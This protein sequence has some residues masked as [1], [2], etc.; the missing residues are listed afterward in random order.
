MKIYGEDIYSEAAL[1]AALTNIDH[2]LPFNTLPKDIQ[3]AYIE[4]QHELGDLMS[5]AR[6]MAVRAT[7]DGAW[8]LSVKGNP[9]LLE[10]QLL[11]G[12]PSA[13]ADSPNVLTL[14][15]ITLEEVQ[16]FDADDQKVLVK[17]LTA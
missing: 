10:T 7:S 17:T 6:A 3:A 8:T 1:Q 5:T 4:C 9:V 13:R 14:R 2:V 15:R 12:F 16:L 11:D